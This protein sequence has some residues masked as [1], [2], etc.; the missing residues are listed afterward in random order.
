MRTVSLVL[1]SLL[2]VAPSASGGELHVLAI[3]GGGERIDNFASHLAHLH[4]LVALLRTAGVPGDHLTVL[5]SDGADPAPDLATRGPEPE[6]AWLLQGTHAEPLLAE[7]TRFE[8]STV[9]GVEVRPATVAS[10]TQVIRELRGRLRAG[11]TLLVYVTDHGTQSQRDPTGNRITL[12]GARASISVAELGTLL[13]RLPAGVRVVSLMSQCYSGGFAYLHEA[14]ERSRVP[15]GHT[16]GY[17][18]STPDRPA[19]GCY[20]EVRGAKAVGHSFEFLSALARHGRFVAA[21]AEVVTSDDTPDCPLRSSDVYLAELLGRHTPPRVSE[22]AFAD[23]L[24]AGAR[25]DPAYVEELRLVDRIV[26]S[27]GIGRPS[28]LV[29][30]E[31]Q[32]GRLFGF[33]DTLDAEARIWQAALGDL[34]QANLD[35]FIAAHPD[36][37]PGRA[38]G[39]DPRPP[40]ERHTQLLRLLPDLFAFVA[41][42]RARL[43]QAQRLL[44]GLSAADEL[45]Y[46]T[47]IRVAALLRIRFLLT[48]I[49]GR[50]W[51]ARH[52]KEAAA[53]DGLVRCEDL[54]LAVPRAPAAETPAR[55]KLPPFS[56]D[57]AR[58]ADL[59]PGWIGITFAPV[60]VSRRQR[61]QLPAGA[62]TV[63]EVLPRSPAAAA[64]LRRGDIIIGAPGR[65]FAHNRLVRP[66]IAATPPGSPVALEVLRA[67]K[68]SPTTVIA[69]EA[70]QPAR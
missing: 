59:R 19:Y 21:H 24:L 49:A 38:K 69:R 9:P 41:T 40:A 29:E 22:P 7:L 5:A 3:N 10:L 8:T 50:E 35:A 56:E 39:R 63:T 46:R 11:D 14:R 44:A 68:P 32:L 54:T 31:A 13:A 53:Y 12:W 36:R 15:R 70:P 4:Q 23:S 57:V 1:A 67:G 20:P 61:L 16:C 26:A 25:G 52:P 30:L 18:S 28:S 48:S 6:H 43:A 47:E 45:G 17:F 51:L 62:V 34:N 37:L 65:P 64:G 58:A 66:A 42:D 60:G 27:Y 2:A 33:L 55:A